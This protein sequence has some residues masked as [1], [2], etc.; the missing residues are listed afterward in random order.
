M[1]GQVAQLAVGRLEPLGAIGHDQLE[2]LD[3]ALEGAGVVP[4]AAECAGALQDLDRFEGFLDD[5]QLVGMAE[6][7]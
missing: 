6:P 2:A 7:R 5:Q 1:G 3:V 4:L